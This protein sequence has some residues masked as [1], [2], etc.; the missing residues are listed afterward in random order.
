LA[1]DTPAAAPARADAHGVAVVELFTS[2]GCS[3]C[4]AA[5]DVLADLSRSPRSP[6]AGGLV[7]TLAFHV[8]YWDDLGWPDRFASPELT[9]R[10]R[11]Y[12]RAFG[13]RGMYTPQM[14][15]G[16]TEQFTGSDRDSADAAIA[17]ALAHPAPVHLTLRAKKIVPGSFA[18][19]WTATGV[20]AGEQLSLALVE[21]ATSTAVRAGENAGRTLH[22][23]NV[24]RA[25]VSLP[26]SGPSGTATLALPAGKTMG[27]G[28]VVAFAQHP[29]SAGGGMP[30]DGATSTPLPE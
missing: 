11:G 9:A 21:T 4:P 5:D 30:V 12:A 14:V 29:A 23:A 27:P 20:P 15:V 26:L 25:L 10:Q 17:R 19:D 2:E 7:F 16:G 3:S 22:H 18:V 8:D 13:L 1:D 28:A 24:V 6:A